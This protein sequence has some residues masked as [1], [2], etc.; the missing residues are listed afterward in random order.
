MSALVRT[1]AEA[2]LEI[3]RLEAEIEALRASVTA[4]ADIAQGFYLRMIEAQERGS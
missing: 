4:S 1:L 3:A 2:R